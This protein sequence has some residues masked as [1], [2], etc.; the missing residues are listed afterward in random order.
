MDEDIATYEH[1]VFWSKVY[2]V[3]FLLGFLIIK[4]NF[5]DHIIE[6]GKNNHN[7][8]N[9]V[10]HCVIAFLLFVCMITQ[11][12]R[13]TQLDIVCGEQN[14]GIAIQAVLYPLILVYGLAI[15][16]LILVPI[17]KKCFSIFFGNPIITFFFNFRGD[18]DTLVKKYLSSNRS[19]LTHLN[20][21]LEHEPYLLFNELEG[22]KYSYS[23]NNLIWKSFDDIH[24]QLENATGSTL[25]QNSEFVNLKKSLLKS[26]IKRDNIGETFWIIGIGII[27]IQLGFNFLLYQNCSSL[28]RTQDD[29]EQY[30]EEKLK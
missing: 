27:T 19:E 21:L 18:I 23:K 16:T 25:S 9:W 29:F 13:A 4:L 5:I 26:I 24:S 8:V 1:I 6:N 11:Y 10:Y 3:S 28:K 22:D 7:T 12:N 15:T 30:V 2:F 20:F 17:K 14:L